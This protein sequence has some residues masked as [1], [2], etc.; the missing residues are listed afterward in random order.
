MGQRSGT[1]LERNVSRLFRLAGFNTQNNVFIEGYEID[2]F[3]QVESYNIV[4]ECKQYERSSL[5]VR[6][7]IH[8][9]ESKNKIIK[10]SKVLLVLVGCNITQKDYQLAQQFGITI[11]NEEWLEHLMD[12]VST[13]K[14]KVKFE[15]LASLNINLIQPKIDEILRRLDDLSNMIVNREKEINNENAAQVFEAML[16]EGIEE[17]IYI[18][19]EIG[20]INGY[21]EE[22]MQIINP[23]KE[24]MCGLPST[25]YSSIYTSFKNSIENGIS[26]GELT[27]KKQLKEIRGFFK[28]IDKYLKR[29]NGDTSILTSQQYDYIK[30]KIIERDEPGKLY[31]ASV[32]LSRIEDAFGYDKNVKIIEEGY[33]K[34]NSVG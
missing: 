20:K 24:D 10:A 14:E 9:W 21:A 26:S 18:V 32:L 11:W 30:K 28:E 7:L 33:K 34:L 25:F 8:Q 6:N 5:S 12:L 4:I 23:I 17:L 29:Q 13:D 31:E 27:D 16:N 3:V 19:K 15:I 22:K 1:L 2:V